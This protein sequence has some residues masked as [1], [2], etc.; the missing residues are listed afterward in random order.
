MTAE[1]LG[2]ELEIFAH[3]VNWKRYWASLIRRYIRGDVLEV[4]AGI[5]TNTPYLKDLQTSSWT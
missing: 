3:A 4:G 1:Y 5:G 2:H